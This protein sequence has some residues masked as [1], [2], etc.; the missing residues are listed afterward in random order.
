MSGP[1]SCG[2][3]RKGTAEAWT[4]VRAGRVLSPEKSRIPGADAVAPDGRQHCGAAS[5]RRAADPAWSLTPS[6]HG[7]SANGNQESLESAA[8]EEGAAVR[9]GNPQGVSQR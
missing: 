6:T 3:A 4:G 7:N 9:A 8:E 5:A 2:G 1:E